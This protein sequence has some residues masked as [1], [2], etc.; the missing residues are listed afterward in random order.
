M[1]AFALFD[2]L[3]VKDPVELEEY[4]Q[5]VLPV[6]Q[7]YGGIYRCVGGR[8]R[9]TEGNWSPAYLVMIEFE[10]YEMA[11]EWYDSADYAELKKRRLSAVESK[12]VIFEGL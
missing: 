8:L 12:A 5:A 4:K 1:A 7:K 10:S 2:N 6:V 9:K 3:R 11:N